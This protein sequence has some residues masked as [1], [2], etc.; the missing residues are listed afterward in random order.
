MGSEKTEAGVYLVLI[1]AEEQYSL[2]PKYLSIPTGWRAVK[3]GTQAECAQFVD[4]VWTDMRPLSLRIKM[5]GARKS[6][7]S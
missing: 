1:N 2:W 5:D 4:E 6:D 7:P 3:E